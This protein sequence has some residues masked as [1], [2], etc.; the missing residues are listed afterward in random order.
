LAQNMQ[1][2]PCISVGIRLEKAEVGPTSGPT[3]C[4]LS[5]VRGRGLADGAAARAELAQQGP[6]AARLVGGRAHRGPALPRLERRRDL[7][8]DPRVE[9]SWR[10]CCG[11]GAELA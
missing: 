4:P 8:R 3:W 5:P 7:R 6:H 2:G 10:N 11:G 1:V 9:L